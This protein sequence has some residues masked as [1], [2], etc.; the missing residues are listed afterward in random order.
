[1][2]EELPFW[3]LSP[4]VTLA[5][6]RQCCGKTLPCLKNSCDLTVV[7]AL[8]G[9]SLRVLLLALAC[10]CWSLLLSIHKISFYLSAARQWPGP[11]WLA[12]LLCYLPALFICSVAFI[13]C[14]FVWEKNCMVTK[15]RETQLSI[16]YTCVFF[17]V[18]LCSVTTYHYCHL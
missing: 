1:M 5:L 9:I 8:A 2:I 16:H 18:V 3:T 11:C 17:F 13:Q 10:D 15:K 14:R 6:A 4:L 7:L 12:T